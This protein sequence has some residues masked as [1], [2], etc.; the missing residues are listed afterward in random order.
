MTLDISLPTSNVLHCVDGGVSII[1]KENGTL[2]TVADFCGMD[3]DIAN[4]VFMISTHNI[5]YVSVYQYFPYNN[6]P[7][8]I[9]AKSSNHMGVFVIAS[10]KPI[11]S[12]PY[13]TTISRKVL[14]IYIHFEHISVEMNYPSHISLLLQVWP[15]DMIQ[16]PYQKG[17]CVNPSVIYK[18]TM[19]TFCH[20]LEL[21]IHGNVD[22]QVYATLIEVY[23][24]SKYAISNKE[25]HKSLDVTYTA[26]DDIY[27]Y[28]K[29][30]KT[31]GGT[32]DW[33]IAELQKWISQS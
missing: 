3:V 2:T 14:F 28:A 4:P 21:I 24:T 31:I 1:Q 25:D 32:I 15:L 16:S 6:V 13:V 7:A 5:I 29:L 8:N 11:I 26:E 19:E 20:R 17:G 10:R 9:K 27:G 18:P 23:D 12:S 33:V 22:G 30:S